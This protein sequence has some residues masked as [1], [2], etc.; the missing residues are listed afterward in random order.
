MN[1]LFDKIPQPAR[2]VV[3]G[4]V[5]LV[6]FWVFLRLFASIFGLL[7]MLVVAA[8]IS[9]AAEHLLSTRNPYG[10]VGN[11]LAGLAGAW[12]GS[13]LLG[14]WGPMI[15]G[16][17][18]LPGIGGAAIVA[19]LLHL[20]LR[21]DRANL[22]EAFKAKADPNDRLLMSQLEDYRLVEVLGR[23]ANSKV[24]KGLP[25]KTL[26]L[27]GSVA[28]K[29]LSEEVT[30]GAEFLSR[31]NREVNIAHQLDHPGI[32]KVL[33]WGEQ[34]GLYY[35]IME[36]VDGGTLNLEMQTG[37][38]PLT[39]AIDYI[40]QIMTAL[41]YAHDKQII[42]RDVKP[43]NILVSRGKCKLADFG[44]GRA[45][46]DDVCLTQEGTVLGT[47]AYIAPEQVK[48]LV[49]T[50]ACDQYALGVMF[51]EI[52]TGERPFVSDNS[53]TLLLHQMQKKAPSAKELRPELSDKLCAIA[54]KMME[55]NPE[56]RYPNLQ[57]ALDDLR[58]LGVKG[59]LR[60]N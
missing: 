40:S 42:H 13:R 26:S 15:A 52:L 21:A 58:A 22:L 14:N 60:A 45:L 18:I 9:M 55:K 51:F 57:S 34:D 30:Q 4:L 37:R 36:H 24:Y 25:E 23:G 39:K 3:R 49:P 31:Y 20:K 27:S 46:L 10:L 50:A 17:R 8:G 38:L 41:Q 48:G 5:A 11:V 1:T 19:I 47:P 32:V 6:G 53:M 35:L 29:I 16:I 44:L 7:V 33:K 56:D 28:C 2:P 54:A 12:L 59:L 43:D